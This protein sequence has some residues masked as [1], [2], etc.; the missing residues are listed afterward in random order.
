MHKISS[1]FLKNKGSRQ[2]IIKNT[3]W[4]AAGTTLTKIIRI[5]VIIYVARVLGSES[6]GIFAYTI[7]LV[8]IFALFSD[9][10]LTSILTKELSGESPEK[11]E[12]LATTVIVKLFFLI[13][14]VCL[15]ALFAPII[16]KFD[17][18]KPLLI[19][20]A[21]TLALE[22][23]QGFFYSITRSQNKMEVEAGLS[24]FTEIVV[25]S[26]IL[27]SFFRN[28]TIEYLAYSYM[29]GNLIGVIITVLILRSHLIKTI[30]LFNKKF[31]WSILTRSGPFAIMSAFG[32]FST[33]IDSVI[34]GEFGTPHTLGLYA[35]AQKPIGLMRVLPNFLSISLFPL[36]NKLSFTDE[37]ERLSKLLEKSATA[38]LAMALPIVVGGIIIANPLL[39]KLFGEEFGGATLTFQLLLVSILIIFPASMISDLIIAKNKQKIFIKSS[40][41][42]ALTN[43][44]LDL[45]LIP[46]YGITGS[47]FATIVSVL[48]VNLVILY[49]AKKIMEFNIITKIGKIVIST[50]LM[51][52]CTLTMLSFGLQLIYVILVSALVYVVILVIFKEELVKELVIGIKK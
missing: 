8:A 27:A 20:M 23:L 9:I 12:Y 16:S 44:I 22:S 24:V 42:G 19:I 28:P 43:V 10:G 15:A 35:A 31:L 11:E 39:I 17:E 30:K 5:A 36:I 14:S 45:I 52:L 6:Y 48:V 25:T 2:I 7:S 18:A 41:L 3:F 50:I 33:N 51:A 49:E 29:I 1:F 34:I 26:L 38:A 32:I 46:K 13:L 4:V 40:I 37:K 21:V 47:A